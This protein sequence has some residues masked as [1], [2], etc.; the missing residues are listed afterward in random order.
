MGDVL[1]DINSRRGLV[2]ELGERGN[3][4][5]IQALVPLGNMFQ[6]VS[7]LRSISKGRAN[8]SMKLAK[9]EFIPPNVEKDIIAEF[10]REEEA[11]G[12]AA[13]LDRARRLGP[14]VC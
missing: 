14:S 8:Y 10:K 3:T 12:D 4:K 11:C 2:Q 7:Q 13:G 1:G 6:Y 9:Y 5:T